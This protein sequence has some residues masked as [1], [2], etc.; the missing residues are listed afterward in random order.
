M[1]AAAAFTRQV[2][3]NIFLKLVRLRHLHARRSGQ[4]RYERFKPVA[5]VRASVAR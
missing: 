2:K 5:G 1:T 3:R 4:L